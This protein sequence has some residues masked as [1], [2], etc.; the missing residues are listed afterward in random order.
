MVQARNMVLDSVLITSKRRPERDKGMSH[1]DERFCRDC[2]HLVGRRHYTET[3]EEWRC[4]SS[5][6]VLATGK[7]VVTG[8]TTY[9]LRFETCYDCRSDDAGCGSVGSWFEAYRQD[10]PEIVAGAER[11][12][13][14][15]LAELDGLGGKDG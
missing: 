4:H 11:T 9:N 12:A 2:R 7:D 15:L 10:R 1:E 5:R 6:N 8:A 14:N 13:K 3:A